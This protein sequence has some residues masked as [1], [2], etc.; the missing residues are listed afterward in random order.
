MKNRVFYPWKKTDADHAQLRSN[1]APF[2]ILQELVNS[3]WVSVKRLEVSVKLNPRDVNVD[4]DLHDV[5][6]KRESS[7]GVEGTH[8]IILVVEAVQTKDGGYSSWI[9]V[10]RGFDRQED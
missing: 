7:G 4:R 6:G 9:E 8:R 5:I 2:C 1:T 10:W 3:H